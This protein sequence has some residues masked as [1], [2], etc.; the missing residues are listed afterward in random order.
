MSSK[1]KSG[2]GVSGVETAEVTDQNFPNILSGINQLTCKSLIP[3]STFAKEKISRQLVSCD[4]CSDTPG[5]LTC[6]DLEQS[7]LSCMKENNSKQNHSVENLSLYAMAD[8]TNSA[9]DNGSSQYLLSL[10]QNGASLKDLMSAGEEFFHPAVDKHNRSS[11]ISSEDMVA[12]EL[13]KVGEFNLLEET[14]MGSEQDSALSSIAGFGEKDGSK[15]EICLP[16]E[17]SL[18]T[19]DDPI[20]PQHS[21]FKPNWNSL[22]PDFTTPIDQIAVQLAD[23][24]HVL[25]DERSAMPSLEGSPFLRSTCGIMG[26]ET[27]YHDWHAQKSYPQFQHSRIGPQRPS[28]H[29]LRSPQMSS[30]IRSM[31]W[32]NYQR[33]PRTPPYTP[34]NV[35]HQP[36]AY[37]RSAPTRFDYPVRNSML[38]RMPDGFPVSQPKLNVQRFPHHHQQPS[39]GHFRMANT[40]KTLTI[41]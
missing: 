24:N 7:I 17:D 1:E 31:D 39:Y 12:S 35:H 37:T 10:L 5:V 3:T 8:Q 40:G 13:S 21:K 18:I 22:E 4:K 6:E 36:F 38:Q 15:I 27:P 33:S 14:R 2:T 34:E 28:Y 41:Y 20:I 29:P 32:K 11:V 19:V 9:N 30:Q 25:S 23:L 26:S 16:E